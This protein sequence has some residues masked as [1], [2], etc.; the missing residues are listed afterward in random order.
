MCIRLH[1][2]SS[3]KD[4]RGICCLTCGGV[5]VGPG[6]VLLDA[7]L[8]HA[9]LLGSVVGAGSQSLDTTFQP[10]DSPNIL[11]LRW[12]EMLVHSP[13]SNSRC[14]P[15]AVGDA[16]EG[17]HDGENDGGDDENYGEDAD[18]EFIV[19]AGVLPDVRESILLVQH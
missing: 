17:Q 3:P 8:V 12:P 1:L 4:F 2:L 7:H 15:D 9:V 16:G 6:Y 5:N 18:T 10:A 19:V 13:V 14:H 11:Y